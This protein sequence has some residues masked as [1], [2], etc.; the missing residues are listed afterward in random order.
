MKR[1]KTYAELKEDARQ[2]AIT[3]QSWFNEHDMSYEELAFW[4]D[5]FEQLGR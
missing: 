3:W 1:R 2:T 5:R 4:Q